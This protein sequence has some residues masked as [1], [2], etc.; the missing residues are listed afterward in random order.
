VSSP[1]E[2]HL[3]H[4]VM[5]GRVVG[6]VQQSG[7]RR[8]RL[9]YEEQRAGVFTP[10]SV[11]MPGPAGRYREGV[12]VPWLEGLL[13]D[14]PETLRQW[15]RRFGVVSLGPF[16]LLRHVGEDVAGAAQLVRPDRL[17]T[18]LGGQGETLNLTAS[19]VAEML[20]RAKADLPVSLD[21][22]S[23]GKFSLAGAQAKIALHRTG[24]AWTDPSGA[25]PSTHVLKPA[26]PGMADQDIVE[27]V[28]MRT[29]AVLGLRVAGAQVATFGDERAVVVSRYDR[30]QRVDGTWVRVHQEDM[31]Q[32][33]GLWPS[34]KYEGDGGPSAAVVADVLHRHSTAPDRGDNRRFAQAL[35]FNWLTC[36]TDA[37]ARNYSLLLS[38]RDVRLAPLYDLNSHLA[39]SDGTG[40]DLSMSVENAFRAS[41][42]TTDAWARYAPALHVDP[43]W[44]RGEI[45][46]QAAA[47]I[48]AMSQAVTEAHA[49]GHDSPVLDR[50]M[51]N[52]EKWVRLCVTPIDI[53]G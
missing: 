14:R 18:V 37:H 13:P 12:L 27:Q 41:T 38:G 22:T 35:I 5:N 1:A 20:R 34:R 39:Y 33:L 53:H 2:D 48:D 46:R 9:R 45:D 29:A 4:L 47:V 43:D 21:D 28:T 50:L 23:G 19:D 42:I 49:S 6:D 44:L 10:L 8:M 40:N 17:D 31:C 36:G 25:V 52:T 51:A 7:K 16:P 3:L 32:A 24:D 30:V 26:I 11:S 15:R